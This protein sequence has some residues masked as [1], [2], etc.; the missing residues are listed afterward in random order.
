MARYMNR[1][2]KIK[3][4]ETQRLLDSAVEDNLIKLEKKICVKGNKAGLEEMA[5]R[6]PTSDMLP[7]ERHDWYCFH[8]H[9]GGEVMLCSGC[10]R[11]YHS[12]CLKEPATEDLKNFT[13]PF[14]KLI[15]NVPE[16][17]NKKERKDLNHL[18]RFTVLRLKQKL[19]MPLLG[20]EPPQM[21]AKANIFDTGDRSA[22]LQ[23]QQQQQQITQQQTCK[24]NV[25]KEDDETWRANF[26]LKQQI[27][28]EQM[29]QRCLS[30][31]YRILDEFRAD[32][33]L[34][35]HNVV[36]YHGVH[37]NMADLARQMFRDCCNDLTEIEL[38][39]DCY[40]Y[41]NEKQ[42]KYWFCK[43]CRPFHDLVHA[44]QKGFPYWPA[45]VIR[46]VEGNSGM[47]DVKFFGGYHQRATVEKENIR[48]I[49]VN[50]HTLQVKRT[51]SWNKACEELRKYQ[52]CL[53][54]VKSDPNFLKEPYGNPFAADESLKAELGGSVTSEESEGGED[55]E[56]GEK[57]EEDTEAD[58]EEAG[59]E[60]KPPAAASCAAVA[61]SESGAS[62]RVSRVKSATTEDEE[63]DE[64]GNDDDSSSEVK[65]ESDSGGPGP[66]PQP[67]TSPPPPLLPTPPPPPQEQQEQQQQQPQQPQQLP[68]KKGRPKK[69]KKE[70]AEDIVSSSSQE[71][72][73]VNACVQTSSKLMKA[74]VAAAGGSAEVKRSPSEKEFKEFAEKLRTEFDQE[75]KRAVNVATRSLER[76]LER[77]KAD[78][79]TEIEELAE[80]N[81]RELEELKK[82]QWCH[83]CEAEAIYWCCWNTAYCSIECQQEHWHKEHKR[84]C[85]RKR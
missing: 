65:E 70:E 53:A 16:S 63:D 66:A 54:K 42:E 1:F 51:S 7:R 59:V 23:Q 9:T 49:S 3:K 75:K 64:E 61:A 45:K 2:Y 31:Q 79:A 6:I 36:L 17:F 18:L 55:D 76:D 21:P 33:Q 35:V 38:C 57:K 5:Y 74:A 8:C 30:N 77:L 47:Y 34:I 69:K 12:A 71:I 24:E 68:K 80:K 83:H 46:P 26:L 67:T 82:K 39:R 28:L 40:R 19:P 56:E 85:R 73:F 81:K 15:Q 62:R 78:H 11:V 84:A 58:V 10:H 50:I 14:C 41:A 29:E 72:R 4:D 37:S 13:C 44:K 52:E 27:S 22:Q 20:R 60:G 25:P 43:P 48:S 32:A